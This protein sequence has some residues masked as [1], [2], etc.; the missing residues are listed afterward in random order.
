MNPIRTRH[1]LLSMILMA[2]LGML[3]SACDAATFD[4]GSNGTGVVNQP[5]GETEVTD[6]GRVVNSRD[7]ILNANVL[8]GADV[9][10]LNGDDLGDVQNVLVNAATGHLPYI[11]VQSSGF[12]GFGSE[13]VLIPFGAFE[14]SK[15][16]EQLLLPFTQPEDIE[17]APVIEADAWAINDP[18]WDDD[19]FDFWNNTEFSTNLVDL[20]SD[21]PIV[22]LSDLIGLG[23]VTLGDLSDGFVNG[24]LVDI[25]AHSAKWIVMDYVNTGLDRYANDVILIPFTAMDWQQVDGLVSFSPDVDLEV[26][27]NAPLTNRGDLFLSGYLAPGFDDELVRYWSQLGYDF[28]TPAPTT[29]RGSDVVETIAPQTVATTAPTSTIEISGAATVTSTVML[30]PTLE[31][32]SGLTVTVVPEEELTTT[33]APAAET[34]TPTLTPAQ[35]AD[36]EVTVVP[37]EELGMTP[38]PAAETTPTPTPA[39]GADIEVTVVPEE[40]LTTTPTSRAD[41]GGDS[42]QSSPVEVTLTEWSIEMPDELPAGEVTFVVINQGQSNHNFAVKGDGIETSLENNLGPGE[43]ARLTLHLT[44]GEYQIEC[45]VGSHAA[46]GMA[47]TLVVRNTAD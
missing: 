32:G 13:D 17:G 43:T 22:L 26:L 35:G 15:T 39:Q 46:Q 44:P 30:T 37:E 9:A 45:P 23:A 6:S 34:V 40:E 1:M 24:V 41:A 31:S 14:L 16:G 4:L 7:L 5:L 10:N 2:T 18:G 20:N 11:I 36:I 25:H 42:S 21:S 33:P 29:D 28:A 8:L 12:L 38:T 47:H 19:L 3:F 27:N